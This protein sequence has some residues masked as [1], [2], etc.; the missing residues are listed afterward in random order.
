MEKIIKDLINRDFADGLFKAKESKYLKKLMDK[1]KM[2]IYLDFHGWL[3][4]F[5]GDKDISK[6]MVKD[7][8]LKKNSKGS[9]GTSSHYIISYTKE[10]YKAKS[11]LI[12]FKNKKSIN[13][14]KV[15]NSIN[16]VL[17][18]FK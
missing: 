15:E 9:Y 5:L 8:G 2:N 6:I 12:E 10:K 16:K 18:K 11:A 4:Q 3:N 7:L 13:Y 1:Y 17:S 14:T